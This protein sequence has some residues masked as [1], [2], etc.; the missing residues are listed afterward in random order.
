[1]KFVHEG[2]WIRVY[3]ETGR[4]RLPLKRYRIHSRESTERIRDKIYVQ[5]LKA[6]SPPAS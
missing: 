1:M 3:V 2:T 6:L 4:R 5:L